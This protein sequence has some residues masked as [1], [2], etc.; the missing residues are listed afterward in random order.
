VCIFLAGH[1]HSYERIYQVLNY[2]LDGCA[3]RWLTMG[4][5]KRS[6]QHSSL[7]T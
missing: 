4:A 2:T 1:V 3:P 5:R 6:S 7:M